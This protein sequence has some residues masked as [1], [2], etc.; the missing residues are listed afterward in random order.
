MIDRLIDRLVPFSGCL[1][2][3]SLLIAISLIRCEAIR[4]APSET[5]T[6]ERL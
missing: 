3:V 5:P 4:L 2:L 6:D 1:L